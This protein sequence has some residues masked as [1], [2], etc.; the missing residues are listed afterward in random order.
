VFE[1]VLEGKETNSFLEAINFG[2]SLQLRLAVP[3]TS[4]L[5]SDTTQELI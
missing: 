4:L 3:K 1:I 5:G 2:T